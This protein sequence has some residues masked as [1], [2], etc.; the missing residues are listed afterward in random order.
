MLNLGFRG[1]QVGI[2]HESLL[3]RFHPDAMELYNRSSNLKQVLEEIRS[4]YV[5]GKEPEGQEAN[6]LGTESILFSK[7][8]PWPAARF[9]GL[10]ARPHVGL[11]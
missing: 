3:K 6:R 5:Q 11:I 4:Q 7:F 10:L 8:K 9:E 2:S 1:R